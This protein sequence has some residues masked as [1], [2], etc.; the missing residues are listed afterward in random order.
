MIAS[1]DLPPEPGVAY[2]VEVPAAV[3]VTVRSVAELVSFV[4]SLYEGVAIADE[5]TAVLFPG[6]DRERVGVADVEQRDG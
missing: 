6:W 3:Y 4:R 5:G 2:R 1:L